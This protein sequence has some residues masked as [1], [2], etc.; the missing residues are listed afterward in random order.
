MSIL[1]KLKKY[2]K[3]NFHSHTFCVWIEV[4][5]EIS[6]NTKINFKSKSGSQY[7]FTEEGVYRTSNH[8]GRVANCRWSMKPINNF[9]NQQTRVGFAKWTDFYHND[10]TS[11]LFYINVDFDKKEVNFYHKD[12]NNY[13]GNAVLRNVTDTAKKIKII[14]GVLNEIGWSKYLEIKDLNETRKNIIEKLIYSE[15]SFNEIKKSI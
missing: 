14:K 8:W 6:Q 5:F 13:D 7:L 4:S 11:K 3:N 15:R 9:K 2:N 10:E 1:D 12:I